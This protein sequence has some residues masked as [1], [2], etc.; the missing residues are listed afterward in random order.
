MRKIKKDLVQ[1]AGF[2]NFLAAAE[3]N[4]DVAVVANVDEAFEALGQR[5]V[6]VVEVEVAVVDD[7][8]IELVAWLKAA[9]APEEAACRLGGNP[10]CLREREESLVL[11]LLV[12]KFAY[13]N[14]IDHHA[15]DAHVMASAD[16]AA[17]AHLYT[18]VEEGA[19]GRDAGYQVDVRRGAMRH[20]HV[21]TAH[22]FQ[23]FAF[24]EDAV[25]HD[26]WCLP[27]QAIAVIGISIEA[28]LGLQLTHQGD[29][30]Q[31]L[32]QVRLHGHLVLLCL[33]A[34][35]PQHG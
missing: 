23:L 28:A 16:V 12:V 8:G 3:A 18:H 27:E 19:D 13:L 21:A 32:R 17:Q 10:K 31:V 1:D 26:G 4:G 6:A 22:Q 11:V 35:H 2:G 14:G 30:T 25:G 33:F 24:T 34:A 7:E 15:H 29:F 9:H 20:H 5:V